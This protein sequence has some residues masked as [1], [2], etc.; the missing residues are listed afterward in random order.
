MEGVAVRR[1][2]GRARDR[3]LRLQ[4]SGL[5]SQPSVCRGVPLGHSNEAAMIH[6]PTSSCGGSGSHGFTIIELVISLAIV[7]LLA[8]ALAALAQPAR[9]VF[10]RVP[11]E[12]ELQ[13]RGR[14]AID[15][16]SNA[17]RSAGRN[18]PATNEL[19]SFA[20]MLP[21]VAFSDP[22]ESGEA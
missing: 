11:A 13:Q 18:V 12:L 9:E 14:T 8:G 6:V 4:V 17:V 1:I 5:G 21:S 15:V 19:G 2:R 22:D 20:D 16:I 7:T 10:D 3:G